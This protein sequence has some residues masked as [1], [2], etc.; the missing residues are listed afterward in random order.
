MV[1]QNSVAT[2]VDETRSI[3]ERALRRSAARGFGT[4]LLADDRAILMLCVIVGLIPIWSVEWFPS[5][6]G[7]VHLY[8]VY[9]MDKL[10]AN[11]AGP[12]R[13]VFQRSYLIDPNLTSYGVIWAASRFVPMLTAE[14][15]FVSTYW[16]TFAGSS[17]Y[18]MRAFGKKVGA[19]GLLLLPFGLGVF[20]HWGFYNFVLGQAIFLFGCGYFFR[21]MERLRTRHV[22]PLAF[23]ITVLALT[24][25]VG[26]IFLLIV[27]GLARTGVALRD[28]LQDASDSRGGVT[29]FLSYLA[30]AARLV[31]AALPALAIIVSFYL[32]RVVTDPHISHGAGF[33]DKIKQ[34][35][36][37]APIQSLD[38]REAFVL[39]PFVV[40]FWLI[41]LR[42]GLSLLRDRERLLASLPRTVPLVAFA[43]FVLIGSVRPVGFAGFDAYERLLPFLFF[44]LIVAFASWTPTAPWRLAIV[45]G[46][47]IAMTGTAALHFRFYRQI[48]MLYSQVEAARVAPPAGSI[49]VA[50]NLLTARSSVAGHSVGWKMNLTDHFRERYA[51][52]YDLPMLN[53]EL[54]APQVFGYFPVIYRPEVTVDAALK[55]EPFKDYKE[56]LAAFERATNLRIAEVSFWPNPDPGMPSRWLDKPGGSPPS[57][58]ISPEREEA[59]RSELRARWQPIPLSNPLAPLTFTHRHPLT[60]LPRAITVVPVSDM[61][62]A[63]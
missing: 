63:P 23:L 7:P 34:V 55:S 41:L 27:V 3:A 15:V 6:D 54:L 19:F 52:E 17:L 25:L 13:H 30:D 1:D 56:P 59:L 21:R 45:A 28:W 57:N 29:I 47:L 58:W 12:F 14:K 49:V 44:L 42:V 62:P 26:V 22:L 11:D 18:L 60:E 20:L 5:V 37:I 46:V 31:L 33:T 38:K 50:A 36:M 35:A 10:A 4:K 39:A 9:L 32:R 48:N 51:R 40:L 16:V 53:I 61:R 24:H 2:A 8:I 43:T